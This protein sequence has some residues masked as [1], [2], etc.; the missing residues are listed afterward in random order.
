MVQNRSKHPQ[1]R[2]LKCLAVPAAL[3]FAVLSLAACG[4][5]SSDSTGSDTTSPPASET[6]KSGES[7]GSGFVAESEKAVAEHEKP[8]TEWTGPTKSPGPVPAGKRVVVITCTNAAPLCLDSAKGVSNAAS[9]VGWEAQI[10]DGGGTPSKWDSAVQT[11]ITGKADAIVMASAQPGLVPDAIAAAKSAGIPVMT[12]LTCEE[13]PPEGVI[14][15]FESPRF[16][17][18]FVLGQWLVSENPEGAE[19]LYL[20]SPEFSCLQH[21]GAGFKAAL[22]KAGS[23]F[24]I[25]E[26]VS[27]P[28]SDTTSPKGAQRVAAMMRSHPDAAGLWAMSEVWAPTFEQAALTTGSSEIV[29]LGVDGETFLPQVREGSKFVMAGPDTFEYGW[30]VVDGLI[31][32]FNDKPQV[33]A[34][35]PFRVIDENNADETTGERITA[36]NN[37]EEEWLKLWGVPAG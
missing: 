19:A 2:L 25:A 22:K 3:F 27:S 11:A 17:A 18:G 1:A 8:L 5:S 24:S 36:D 4:S 37:Y 20:E 15:Q 30:W 10:V 28:Q 6:V 14:A 12:T 35:I 29:G 13:S 32:Y 16:E 26:E 9:A 31:R 7:G 21:A 23:D 33:E 34:E